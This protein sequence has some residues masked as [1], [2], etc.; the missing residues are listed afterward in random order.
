SS[1]RSCG[2]AAASLSSG[3]IRIT[4]GRHA[5]LVPAMGPL[6]SPPR[7]PAAFPP[8]GRA[9]PPLTMPRRRQDVRLPN[10]LLARFYE[11]LLRVPTRR[12]PD[13][14]IGGAHDPYLKRWWVI[15]RNRFFNIYLH[16]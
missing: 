6:P 14:I 5:C 10:A 7:R 11:L 12:G 16:Q 2:A 9:I 4:P 1:S 13:V 3:P 8:R 15:P